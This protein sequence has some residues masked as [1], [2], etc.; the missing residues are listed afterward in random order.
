MSAPSIFYVCVFRVF[1]SPF[2]TIS[3]SDEVLITHFK[4]LRMSICLLDGL[5]LM[6]R[7]ILLHVLLRIL[8]GGNEFDQISCLIT[9]K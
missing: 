2:F 8:N 3:A 5:A 9:I 7:M 4:S 1:T 6:L